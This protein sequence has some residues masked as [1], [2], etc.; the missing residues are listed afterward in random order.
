MGP[1]PLASYINL[2]EISQTLGLSYNRAWTLAAEGRVG[3]PLVIGRSH[4]YSRE[5]LNRFI[6]ERAARGAIAACGS[7]A[8][9]VAREV[10]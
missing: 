9:V 1:A 4:W 7:S 6:A 8:G 3:A 5:L 10:A 2:S